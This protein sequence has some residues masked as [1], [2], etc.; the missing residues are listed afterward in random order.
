MG[1]FRT[2]FGPKKPAAR[3][4]SESVSVGSF[5]LDGGRQEPSLMPG[6][7]APQLVAPARAFTPTQPRQGRRQIVGRQTE[8][9][10]IL[11]ALQEDRSHVVLYAERG[12]GKTSLTNMVVEALRRGD[13]VVAR[14]TCDAD[15]NFDTILR[16]LMRDLPS[17]LLAAQEHDANAEGCEQ[18]LPNRDLRPGD[19]VSLPSRLLCPSL[20]CVIDE[21]DRVEDPATRTR[22]ADAIKQLSDRDVD[23]RFLIV[24]VSENLDQILGQHP[25]IQRNVLGVHLPLFTDRDVSLLIA[26]GARESGFSFSDVGVARIVGLARGM[27]YMAQLLALRL[28]QAASQRDDTVVSDED[29]E[30]AIAGLVADANP[31]V[32]VLYSELTAHGQNGDMIAALREIATAPQDAWGRLTVLQGGG[33]GGVLVGGQPINAACWAPIQEAHVLKSYGSSSGL[34]VFAERSLM[35]HALLLAAQDAAS[36]DPDVG[37]PRPD[38]VPAEPTITRHPPWLQ[39][40]ASRALAARI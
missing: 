16:G 38:T 22:I 35:H 32:L 4:R 2:M 12:R 3:R 18:A 13:V 25:S 23:L 33:G 39:P 27:P 11:Q 28:V 7:R 34:Y 36:R 17:S 31:R 30:S 19:A 10:R 15:S 40:I 1:F 20:V 26:K 8:L 6:R 14:H 24:G 37:D 9:S 21:F 29:F 5:E